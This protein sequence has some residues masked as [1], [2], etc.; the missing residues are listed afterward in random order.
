MVGTIALFAKVLITSVKFSFSHNVHK[1]K[2]QLRTVY[3][4]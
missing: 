1:Q 3:L 2:R 4:L